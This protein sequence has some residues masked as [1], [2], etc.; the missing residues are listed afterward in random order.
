ML[1]NKV[2]D[3]LV[4]CLYVDDMIY[5]G[6]FETFVAEFKSCMMKQF[7]ISDLGTFNTFMGFK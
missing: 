5:M 1:R 2:H 4:V 6:S 3:I 7:E